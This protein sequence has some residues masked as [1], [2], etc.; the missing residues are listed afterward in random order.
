[1]SIEILPEELYLSLVGVGMV[2][3]ARCGC[4]YVCEGLALGAGMT[5]FQ[6]HCAVP[7]RC[8]ACQRVVVIDV[9]GASVTTQSPG[10]GRSQGSCPSCRGDV[11]AYAHTREVRAGDRSTFLDSGE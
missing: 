11:V 1:M 2:I 4:G 7:A 6:T 5:N 3:T 8:G 10:S 9:R